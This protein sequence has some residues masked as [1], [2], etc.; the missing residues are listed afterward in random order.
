MNFK[1]HLYTKIIFKKSKGEN[2]PDKYGNE[3]KN[4]F[5]NLSFNWNEKDSGYIFTSNDCKTILE[6]LEKINEELQKL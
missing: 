4:I 3:I 5:A 1:I 2:A 6:K